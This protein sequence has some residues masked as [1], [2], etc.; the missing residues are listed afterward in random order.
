[1]NHRA[2]LLCVASSVL[3]LGACRSAPTRL[4]SLTILPSQGSMRYAGPP[5]RVDAVHLP[6]EMDRTEIT[7]SVAGGGVEIHE[8]DHW[9][10]PLSKMARETL[11]ADLITRLPSGKVVVAPLDKPDGALGLNVVILQFTPD[12]SGPQFLASW[13]ASA[14][15]S[16]SPGDLITIKSR[17]AETPAEVAAG[18]SELLAHLADAIAAQLA[19]S[20]SPSP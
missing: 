5:V 18:V 14:S 7:T 12:P 9:A 20:A 17:S 10:A 15:K 4:H 2:R 11:T 8:L 6:A 1:M 19:R 3:V 13:Q 16:G